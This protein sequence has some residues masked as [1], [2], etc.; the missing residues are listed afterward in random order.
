[1]YTDSVTCEDSI[2]NGNDT[3]REIKSYRCVLAYIE[4]IPVGREWIGATLHEDPSLKERRVDISMIPDA[5]FLLK[6]KKEAGSC[7]FID[8]M[9]IRELIGFMHCEND[10][11]VVWR[12]GSYKRVSE[13]AEKKKKGR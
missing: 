8:C 7:R 3:Q 6:R 12:E 4:D 13:L 11:Y 10:Q 2:G 5:R 1:M 9:Q